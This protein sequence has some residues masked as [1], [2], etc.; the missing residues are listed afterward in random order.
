MPTC[1]EGRVDDGLPG[2]HGEELA[3][4]VGEDGTC[5]V[6]FR[7]EALG[8]KLSTPFDLLEL[9]PPGGAVPDLEVIAHA[10]DDDLPLEAACSTSG[11]GTITR[12]CL[13]S[14]ASDALANMKRLIWRDSL[15]K[16]IEPGEP[17]LDE[18]RPALARVDDETP[19]HAAGKHDPVR[20]GLPELG[21]KGQSVLVVE[22]VVVFT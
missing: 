15:L 4:L 13:S 16:G 2:L 11:A 1:T 12:P 9:L 7:C 21:R 8:N 17:A 5:S 10:R 19:V 20:E 22:C 14:S 6:L 3:H 18:R